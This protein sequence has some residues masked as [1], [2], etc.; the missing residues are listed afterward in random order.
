[1]AHFADVT[2]KSGRI[3]SNQ[4]EDIYFS[5]EDAIAESHYV[6]LERNGLPEHWQ[7]KKNYCIAET[8][9]GSGLNFLVTA[10][11]WL[12]D[13]HRGERLDFYSIEAFPLKLK[14]LRKIQAQWKAY[15]ALSSAL[16]A[17]Y[18]TATSGCHTLVFARGRIQLHLI[19]D[20]IKNALSNYS[21]RPDCWYLDGFAPAKNPKMWDHAVLNTIGKLSQKGTRLATFTAAGE[22]RRN[23]VAAGFE[24]KK[25]K[26]FGRKR[27]MLCARKIQLAPENTHPK[28]APWFAPPQPNTDANHVAVIG[29]G[30][31][32]AQIAYHLAQ[33]GLKVHVFES[34]EQVATGASGNQAGVLAP[35]LTAQTS[36]GERF[37]IAAF[38]Y[39]LNQLSSLQEAGHNV[40]FIQNG[41]LQLA[42]NETAVSRFTQLAQRDDLPKALLEI[43]NAT[44]ASDIL[45]EPIEQTAMIIENAGSLSPRCLCKAL[46]SHRNIAVQC[47]TNI[48]RITYTEDK[49]SLHLDNGE[50]FDADAVVIANGYQTVDFENKLPIIAARGQ[51]SVATLDNQ[52]GLPLTLG[53][54]G[55]VVQHPVDQSQIVFGASYIRGSADSA[56]KQADTNNNLSELR[57]HAP[58]LAASLTS[59]KSSHA[60]I[61]ATTPDRWPIVGP[62]PDI[63]FYQTQYADIAQGKQ[64][65]SYP[66]A[67]YVEGVYVLSGLGSRGLTSAAYCA[68]LL[69]HTI[70]GLNPP[71]SKQILHSLHPARFMI[72]ALRRNQESQ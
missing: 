20:G 62:L 13:P 12:D 48:D 1:M 57:Q 71:A 30:I 6:F 69:S 43:V 55:Y 50:T 2:I 17:Q 10:R 44:Q 27:E 25:R 59:I 42:H 54:Q 38:L 72:R 24:V 9:F 19:L 28:H 32:G 21:L 16:I 67:K 29:A 22:V 66:K 18:P 53:H 23:L 26:G 14:H 34:A 70:L 33:Q 49:P 63:Y 7:Y 5:E 3:Y 46:L 52:Q 40:G 60:G 4:F 39:Q 11:A 64:Y 15:R 36:L 56:L 51:S 58:S 45:G 37:Y 65:K 68:N 35:R 47:A 31:A 41:L 8:G 61:R